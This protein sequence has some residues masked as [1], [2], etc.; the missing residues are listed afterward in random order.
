[1]KTFYWVVERQ[2][3]GTDNW[4]NWE[5][6]NQTIYDN[7]QEPLKEIRDFIADCKDA[8]HQGYMS[9]YPSF[10]EFRIRKVG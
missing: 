2:L 1:M 9:D 3:H 5:D 8:F 6:E 4:Q 10:E 7:Y